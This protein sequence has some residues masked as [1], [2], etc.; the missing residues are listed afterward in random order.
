MEAPVIPATQSERICI[1]LEEAAELSHIGIV[2]LRKITA[3]PKCPF[4]LWIG[5]TKRVVKVEPFKRW[6]NEQIHI[7]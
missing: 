5:D 2:R 4:V 6:I 1:T 7:E 3:D